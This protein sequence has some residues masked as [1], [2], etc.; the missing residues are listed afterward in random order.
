MSSQPFNWE[1]HFRAVSKAAKA[2]KALAVEFG[3][4]NGQYTIAELIDLLAAKD[5]EIKRIDDAF[6][7]FAPTYPGDFGAWQTAWTTLKSN[8]NNAK[9][10]A[11]NQITAAKLNVVPNNMIVADQAY[12]DVLTSLN[13]SWQ[14]NTAAPNSLSDL[15]NQ[16]TKMGATVDNSPLPQPTPGSD[17]D[18]TALKGANQTIQ[19]VE[20][21]EQAILGGAKGAVKALLPKNFWWYVA[22][23]AAASVIVLPKVLALG[24]K[25]ALRMP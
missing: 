14:Q 19:N 8:Y 17:V 11:Q 5:E 9:S 25:V 3:T 18:L 2:R 23:A 21:A 6:T 24:T 7:A 10:S 1:T 16:L 13:P 20:K 12:K 15:Q 4:V 22:A